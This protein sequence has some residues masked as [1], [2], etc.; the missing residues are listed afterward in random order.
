MYAVLIWK[1]NDNYLTFVQNK[2]G[3]VR[4]FQSLQE[5]DDFVNEHEYDNNMEVISLEPIKG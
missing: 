4:I 3:T 5:A 1:D 2:D